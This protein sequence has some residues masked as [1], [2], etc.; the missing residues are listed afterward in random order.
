MKNQT[1]LSGEHPV[2]HSVS[3]DSGK[4]WKTLEETLPLHLSDFSTTLNLLGLSGKTFQEFFPIIKEETF[5]RSSKVFKKSGIACRGEYLMLS[6]LE[7]PKDGKESLLLDIVQPIGDIPTR[8][9]LSQKACQGIL[10]R[11]ETK[12]VLDKLPPLLLKALKKA[13][14]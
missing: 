3:Q 2:N 14:E 4:D 10:R 1:S 8:L 5:T 9:Y 13:T 6:S 11:A 7:S 12:G